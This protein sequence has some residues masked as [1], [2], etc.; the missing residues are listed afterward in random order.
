MPPSKTYPSTEDYRTPPALAASALGGGIH[1]HNCG[2]MPATGAAARTKQPGHYALASFSAA[3]LCGGR[4]NRLL[5][6]P[7]LQQALKASIAAALGIY[8]IKTV[9]A[10]SLS[11]RVFSTGNA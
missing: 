3:V 9:A 1:H 6:A 4:A 10:S 2:V 11:S 7:P 5:P 8:L